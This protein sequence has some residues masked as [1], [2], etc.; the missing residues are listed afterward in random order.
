MTNSEEGKGKE[1]EQKKKKSKGG[2]ECK[3]RMRR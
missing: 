2:K 1:R 3:Q